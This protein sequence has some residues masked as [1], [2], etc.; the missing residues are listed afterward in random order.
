MFSDRISMLRKER[1]F[2]QKALATK[3]GVSIDSVRRW[4]QNKRSPDLDI[5]SKLAKALETTVSY[6]TGETDN[7]AILVANSEDTKI[8]YNYKDHHLELP[9]TNEGYATFNNFV[10]TIATQHEK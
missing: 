7:P 1:G 8:I 3:L 5:L 10:A 6:I 2:T 4:E 9:A